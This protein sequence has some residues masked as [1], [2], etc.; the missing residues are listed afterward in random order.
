MF[1]RIQPEPHRD[2]ARCLGTIGYVHEKKGDFHVA[3]D[4]YHRQLNME[5]QCLPYDHPN[6]INHLNWIVDT[7]KKLGKTKKALKLLRE[8]LNIHKIRLGANH[9]YIARILMIVGDVLK[10]N[11]RNEALKY[12]EEALSTL[13]KST[14][15]DH[16]T[17]SE[18][19]TYMSSLYSEYGM[20]EDALQCEL[21]VLNLYRRRLSSD[22]TDIA[23]SLRNVGRYYETMNNSSEALR[24]FN[25]SLSLYRANY[26]LD[27]EDVKRGEEDIAILNDKS[28]SLTP[29][30][31]EGNDMKEESVVDPVSTIS[32]QTLSAD[33]LTSESKSNNLNTSSS[34]STFFKTKTCIIL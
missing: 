12:Y 8:K 25:E 34:L 28:I 2:T 18:C 9:S 19:L 31:P 14:P 32:Q 26:G 13:E 11:N 10:D 6:L 15:P 21:K 5:E 33:Y 20:N 17:Y 29:T 24:Y 4:Y 22:H 27:H 30:E 23:Y 7:Y 3:L 1:K 16:Q